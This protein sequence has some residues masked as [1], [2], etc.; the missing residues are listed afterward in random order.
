MKQSEFRALIREEVKK[1][2][3]EGT[4]GQTRDNIDNVKALRT[5]FR[6]PEIALDL[7]EE[8]VDLLNEPQYKKFAQDF[9]NMISN[10][11]DEPIRG[12]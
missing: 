8:L 9:D 11:L 7:I 6:K 1:L 2:V 5:L 12:M 10:K 4:A 3:K